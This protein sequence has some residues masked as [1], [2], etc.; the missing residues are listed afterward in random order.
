MKNTYNIHYKN[1]LFFNLIIVMQTYIISYDLVDKRNYEKIQGAIKSYW[2]WAKILESVWAI[3]TNDSA[4]SIR[5]F[6]QTK[7]D[8]DDRLFV[9]LSWRIA[10][11]QNV[12]CKNE[13][14]QDNL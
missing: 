14:L 10:A 7:I 4:E 11:W 3:K 6:L 1:I 9:I 2:T 5:N 12:I 13:W 8:N